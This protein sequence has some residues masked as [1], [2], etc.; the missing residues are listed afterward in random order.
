MDGGGGGS[1]GGN[2]MAKVR[3]KNHD[4]MANRH[5]LVALPWSQQCSDDRRRGTTAALFPSLVPVQSGKPPSLN[6][7]PVAIKHKRS[8]IIVFIIL[9]HTSLLATDHLLPA[10]W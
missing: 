9:H 1:S 6:S 8:N 4:D 5:R 7:W 10:S 2:Q 3:K